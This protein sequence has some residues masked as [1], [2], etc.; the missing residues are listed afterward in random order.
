MNSGDIPR[1]GCLLPLGVEGGGVGGRA[2]GNFPGSQASKLL[3]A[4]SG[5]QYTKKGTF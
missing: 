4:N 5:F 3:V 2:S 1:L